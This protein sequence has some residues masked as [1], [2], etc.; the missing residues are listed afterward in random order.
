MDP[1]NAPGVTP[2]KDTNKMDPLANAAVGISQPFGGGGVINTPNIMSNAPSVTPESED[3]RMIH[4]RM[5]WNH[6]MLDMKSSPFQHLSV[7]RKDDGTRVIFILH[8]NQPVT[9]EDDGVMFPSDS[10]VTSLR[11][12][13]P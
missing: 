10:L 8:N 9:L 6:W 2:W 4:M 7:A 13:S 1:L 11:M 3:L 12:I 5:R